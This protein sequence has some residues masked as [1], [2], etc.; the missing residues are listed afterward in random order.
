MTTDAPATAALTLAHVA[1]G[2][3]T[4]TTLGVYFLA[5]AYATFAS[6]R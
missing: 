1:F 4:L 2:L 6:A 3:Y 5:S